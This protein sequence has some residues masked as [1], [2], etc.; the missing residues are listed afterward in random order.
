MTDLK[1]LNKTESEKQEGRT[2]S[3][4]SKRDKKAFRRSYHEDHSGSKSRRAHAKRASFDLET[5]LTDFWK[6]L[7]RSL[8]DEIK[9]TAN[10]VYRSGSRNAANR[11]PEQLNRTLCTQNTTPHRPKKIKPTAVLE[12]EK[13]RMKCAWTRILY[14]Q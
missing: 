9:C 3:N 1:G 6:K 7:R 4:C 14:D 10:Q 8:I 11:H 2:A 12:P 5:R 13:N